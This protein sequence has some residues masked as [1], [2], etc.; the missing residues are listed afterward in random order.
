MHIFS[1]IGATLE[2]AAGSLEMWVAAGFP[3]LSRADFTARKSACDICPKL[4]AT[5][6][7]PACGVCGCST[8]LK[9][10]LATEKC[11]LGKWP[12]QAPR[13]PAAETPHRG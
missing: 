7:G 1:V 9:P 4:R 2:E 13:S 10:W 5:L 8:H 3:V 11:K 12:L 6:I